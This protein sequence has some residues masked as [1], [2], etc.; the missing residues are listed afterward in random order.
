MDTNWN[1][2]LSLTREKDQSNAGRHESPWDLEPC[3]IQISEDEDK[4]S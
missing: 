3:N 4:E 2:A 1:S